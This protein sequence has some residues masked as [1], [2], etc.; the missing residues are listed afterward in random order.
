[1]P[2]FTQSRSR[3]LSRRVLRAISGR[4]SKRDRLAMEGGKFAINDPEASDWVSFD[5]IVEGR[6]M[7]LNLSGVD[8][9]RAHTLTLIATTHQPGEHGPYL[10]MVTTR[11]L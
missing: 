10:R 2:V 4:V 8:F 7:R 9:R 6:A 3:W 11:R 1:M 5:S